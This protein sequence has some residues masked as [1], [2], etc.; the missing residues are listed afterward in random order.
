MRRIPRTTSP[1]MLSTQHPRPRRSRS[2]HHPRAS[3]T[4][5]IPRRASKRTHI[6]PPTHLPRE[7]SITQL[8]RSSTIHKWHIAIERD[9]VEAEV[10][11]AR[12]HHAVTTDRENRPDDRAGETIV[13]VVELVDREGA[14][15]ERGAEDGRVHRDEL[16]HRRVVVGE[17]L[18]LGV[19]VE[20][21]EAEA[22]EGG[23][24]VARGERFQGVVDF[25]AVPGADGAVVHDLPK[26]CAQLRSTQGHIRLANGEE[27]GSKSAN[28]P[29]QEYLEDGRGDEAVEQ[30]DDGV[31]RVPEGANSDLADEDDDDGDEGAEHGRGPDGDDVFAERVGEF[32]VDDFAVLEVDLWRC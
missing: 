9:V 19:E 10:P 30:P 8:H 23:G 1:M 27:M 25:V 26:S 20:V 6:L 32:G 3:T 22:C 24:A 14:G 7:N 13:P 29:F 16:P 21:E 12:I 2:T 5:R 17:H 31:V 18:Q 15:D 28:Q 11:D 4:I